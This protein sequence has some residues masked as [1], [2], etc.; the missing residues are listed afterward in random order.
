MLDNPLMLQVKSPVVDAIHQQSNKFAIGVEKKA[1]GGS[2][3]N[4]SPVSKWL[5]VEDYLDSSI[6]S[7]YQ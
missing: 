1:T 5:F 3:L 4:D 2:D 6:V 7:C